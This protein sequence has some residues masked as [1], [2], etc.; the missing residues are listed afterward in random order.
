MAYRVAFAALAVAMVAGVLG[1]GGSGKSNSSVPVITIKQPARTV[2]LGV[3]SS[4]MEPTILCKKGSGNPGCT[5]TVNDGIVVQEPAPRIHRGDI[6]VF[7]TPR[8]AALKCGEGGKFVKRVIALPGETVREDDH[9]FIWIRAP[10]SKTFHKLTEPYVP[11]VSRLDDSQHFGETWHVPADAY[12]TV[13][14]NRAQSCDSRVWGGVTG[15]DVIGKVV[16]I[17]G[18]S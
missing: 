13:G 3:T 7:R 18:P 6:I 5:G 17:L 16:K 9:G 12:F 4:A 15:G 2:T 1:C 8:E 11:A 10:R 14:D